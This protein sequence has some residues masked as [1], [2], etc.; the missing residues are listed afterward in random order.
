MSYTDATATSG[1]FLHGA[2]ID[3]PYYSS[4]NFNQYLKKSGDN[5]VHCIEDYRTFRLKQITYNS[6]LKEQI[7][8]GIKSQVTFTGTDISGFLTVGES[9][10]ESIVW[11]RR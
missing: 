9:I 8:M 6:H 1:Q 2:N 7:K 11:N 3:F 10:N 5:Y 4:S